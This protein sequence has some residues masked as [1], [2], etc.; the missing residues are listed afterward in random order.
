MGIC[1]KRELHDSRATCCCQMQQRW[2]ILATARPQVINPVLKDPHK[3]AHKGA[4][5]S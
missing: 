3:D 5:L 1:A 2:H 4:K